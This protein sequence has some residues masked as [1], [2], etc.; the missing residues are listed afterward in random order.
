MYLCFPYENANGL[1]TEV[2]NGTQNIELQIISSLDIVQKM[3][4]LLH[5]IEDSAHKAFAAKMLHTSEVSQNYTGTLSGSMPV[6]SN[7]KMH[8]SDDIYSMHS[9]FQQCNLN[10]QKVYAIGEF[11]FVDS[12][13]TQK[14]TCIVESV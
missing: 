6:G 10:F 1:L 9:L 3:P 5:P 11:V 12:Q 7:I 8:F 2:F 14:Q 13:F 4:I